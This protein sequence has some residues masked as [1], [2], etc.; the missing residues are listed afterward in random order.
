LTEKIIDF[1]AHIYPEKIADK[2]AENVGK[3]YGLEMD[4]GGSVKELLRSGKEGMVSHFVVQSVATKPQ[5]VQS[6]NDFIAQTCKNSG[7]SMIGLGTLHPD[8]E[9]PQQEIERC[10][11][12]GLKGIKLHPDCQKFNMD[13][14]RMLPIYKA[15]EGKLPILVHCGD[16]R[17]DYSHPRRLANV[18]DTFPKLDVVAAHFGGWSVYDLAVEYLENR[19]CWLDTSSSLAFIGSR[20]GQELIRLYGADRMVFGTDFPMWGHKQELER[21]YALGLTEE[22]NRRILYQNACE[23]LKMSI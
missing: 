18:L 21:F 12:I 6:I 7:G 23:V 9:N 1:H 16:Y 5:Q 3:F 4:H 13:D 8:M 17:Y 19:R 10:M 14:S 22:E 2:A 11:A 15:L 20:R